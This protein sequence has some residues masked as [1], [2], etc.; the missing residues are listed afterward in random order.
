M[1]KIMIID[2]NTLFR[3]SLGKS[4]FARFPAAEI[5]ETGSGAEGLQK[6][7]AFAPQLIFIDIY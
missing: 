4:L 3:K 5:Q 2:S 6:V 1:F 7:G